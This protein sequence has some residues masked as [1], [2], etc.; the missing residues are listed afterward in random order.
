MALA[1]ACAVTAC[2]VTACGPTDAP[3]SSTATVTAPV[4]PPERIEVDPANAGKAIEIATQPTTRSVLLGRI[5]GGAFEG[6]GFDVEYDLGAGPLVAVNEILQDGG[7]D[8]Y[9]VAPPTALR[10]LL[11]VPPEDV[12][13]DDALAYR[14]AVTRYEERFGFVAL[15]ATPYT[16]TDAVALVVSPKAVDR[17]GPA[18][19]QVVAA[20]QDGL[21]PSVLAG[22]TSRVDAGERAE[23][24]AADYLR[25]YLS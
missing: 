6:A 21:T 22:L 15:P 4:A 1:L 20:A 7:I 16:G 8:A 14:E 3:E 13:K 17:L 24:V 5:F 10:A 9:P 25:R 12:P 18:A 19:S 11:G 2:V 23:D